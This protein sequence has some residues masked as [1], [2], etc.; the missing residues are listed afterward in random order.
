MRTK[1][2]VSR[3]RA[4]RDAGDADPLRPELLG[5]G[6][7]EVDQRCLGRAV[8]D[9]PPSGSKKAF[10]EATLTIVPVRGGAM[11]L[12]AARVARSAAKK[13][14]SRDAAKSAS[15]RLRNPS[16]RSVRRRRC[17]PG[18]RCDRAAQRR[19]PPVAPGRRLGKVDGD[20]RDPVESVQ[21]VGRPC[22][23]NYERPLHRRALAATARPMPLLAPVTTATLPASS[24][25]MDRNV[26]AAALQAA[27]GRAG[28]SGYGLIGDSGYI[29]K[30]G[31]RARCGAGSD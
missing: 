18:R 19:R 14:S 11:C 2:Q 24:R 16:V 23:R 31:V 15:V 5:E 13:L 12:T 25:S 3:D 29:A 28:L 8:V 22:A 1:P 21:R 20:R 27:R 6:L 7:G 26:A 10:T 9:T 30:P 17:S 4:R